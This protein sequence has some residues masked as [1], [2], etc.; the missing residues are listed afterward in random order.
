MNLADGDLND[1]SLDKKQWI[2]H[3]EDQLTKQLGSVV[4]NKA[5]QNISRARSSRNLNNNNNATTTSGYKPGNSK[6]AAITTTSP[7]SPVTPTTPTTPTTPNTPNTPGTPSSNKNHQP[8]ISTSTSFA[9][10]YIKPFLRPD[11]KADR[12]SLVK[13]LLHLLENEPIR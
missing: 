1:L 7:I 5:R 10:S 8:H 9:K 13:E 12:L 2:L 11:K 3:N 6:H 4:N